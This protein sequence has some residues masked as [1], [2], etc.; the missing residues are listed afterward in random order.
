MAENKRDFTEKVHLTSFRENP[1]IISTVF[2]ALFAIIVLVSNAGLP[3]AGYFV[4][5]EATDVSRY[6]DD[7]SIGVPPFIPT[8]HVYDRVDCYECQRFYLEILPLVV[9]DYVKYGDLRI[10]F[11]DFPNFLDDSSVEKSKSLKCFLKEGKYFDLKNAAATYEG[12]FDT[13]Y[14]GAMASEFEL[15]NF[16]ECLE[17][18]EVFDEIINEFIKAE[19]RG[20]RNTPAFFLDNV[21]LQEFDDYKSFKKILDEILG[22]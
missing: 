5:E 4:K 7:A 15:Q 20:V 11:H 1:W 2:L 14:F 22:N 6:Y 17:S 3:S 13:A 10:T 9:D 21:K 19:Q 8:L 16:N 12:I 18:E